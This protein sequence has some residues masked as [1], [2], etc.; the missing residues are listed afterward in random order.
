M[1]LIPYFTSLIDSV[2]GQR[3]RGRRGERAAGARTRHLDPVL[4]C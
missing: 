2:R 4:G 3:I 1:R